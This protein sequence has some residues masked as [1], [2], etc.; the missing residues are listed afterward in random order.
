MCSLARLRCCRR[1]LKT[2]RSKL[3]MRHSTSLAAERAHALR[4]ARDLAIAAAAVA[5]DRGV[6]VA[7]VDEALATCKGHERRAVS[8]RS[9]ADEAYTA[10]GER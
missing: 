2:L 5:S 10:Q 6:A 1:R 4:H 3:I 7:A 8:E 9:Q